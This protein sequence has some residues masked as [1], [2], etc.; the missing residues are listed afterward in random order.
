[1]PGKDLVLTAASFEV[2]SMCNNDLLNACSTADT[3]LDVLTNQPF[4]GVSTAGQVDS[5]KCL[6]RHTYMSI[7]NSATFKV[8]NQQGK[9]RIALNPLNL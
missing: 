7:P 4:S 6:K 8:N 3:Y 1:M 2:N 5:N 9:K